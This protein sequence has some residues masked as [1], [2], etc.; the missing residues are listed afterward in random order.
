MNRD[1]FDDDFSRRFAA[2]RSAF[3]REFDQMKRRGKILS[4]I[5]IPIYIIG[6]LL[7]LGLLAVALYGL[8]RYVGLI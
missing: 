6:A 5:I 7:I 3:D 8:A 2:Q 4:A 1:P